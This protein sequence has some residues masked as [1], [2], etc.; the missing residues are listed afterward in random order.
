M[1]R[2]R[3]FI[4]LLCGAAAWP[5]V[6]RAQQGDRVRRIGVLMPATADDAE[7]QA[8]LGAFLQ[9]LALSGWNIGRNVRIE[10]RWATSNAADI[11]KHAAELAALRRPICPR[12]QKKSPCNRSFLRNH[13]PTRGRT[14][15]IMMV[16]AIGGMPGAGAAS[17]TPSKARDC[18]FDW[19]RQCVYRHL[20]DTSGLSSSQILVAQGVEEV[21]LPFVDVIFDTIL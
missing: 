21:L 15:P 16:G 6:A 8:R 17:M 2:R 10:T 19:F 4:T 7:F 5:L 3:E 13:P 1:I 12:A 20:R 11:R 9:G 18:R 14:V